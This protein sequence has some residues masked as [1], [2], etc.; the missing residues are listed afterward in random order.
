M[1]L[2]EAQKLA[3]LSLYKAAI[4]YH[5]QANKYF[6]DGRQDLGVKS[7]EAASAAYLEYLTRYPHDKQAY[8]LTFYLGETY[9]YSLHF[10]KAA[11]MLLVG[12]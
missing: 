8:E 1:R 2:R 5:N 10:D 7:F 4:Y 9:Y 3:R 11:D 6:E 12:L